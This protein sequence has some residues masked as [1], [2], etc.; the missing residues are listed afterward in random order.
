M[1]VLTQYDPKPIPS[2]A[3]DWHA[4]DD[5]TYDGTEGSPVGWG[6]TEADA[7]ADLKQQVE[8]D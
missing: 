5:S 8:E 7:I 4:I 6:A 3:F 2:R 1:K